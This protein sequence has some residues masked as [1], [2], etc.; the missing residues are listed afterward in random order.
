[1]NNRS[2]FSQISFRQRIWLFLTL[3][4]IFVIIAL[5]VLL[6]SPSELKETIS[7]N[8]NRSIQDIAPKLGVTGRGLARELGLQL[9]APKKKSLSSLRVTEENLQHSIEHLL[10]HRD[11][12][13]K[14]YIYTGLF[15]W[16]LVFLVRLGRPDGS[17]IKNRRYW[18]PKIPYIIALLF[19]VIVAGFIL[20]KSP[21]PMEGAVKIFKSMIGLYPDPIAKAIAFTFFIILAVVGNK[22]ICG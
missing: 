1:M 16:G 7:F 5:G 13:L 15:I 18:Y 2:W 12:I 9:D 3:A 4:G 6:D 19:S 14:Y 17:D 20:G 22:I 21:N 10:S 11:S 8:V